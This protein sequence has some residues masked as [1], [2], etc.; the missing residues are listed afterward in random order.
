MIMQALENTIFTKV[1]SKTLHHVQA[2]KYEAAEGLVADIYEQMRRDL[3]VA[4]PF[5]LHS[6]LPQVMAGVWSIMRESMIAGP[7]NRAYLEAVAA[8]IAKIN[9]C[10]FCLEL[11]TGLMKGASADEGVA[12]LLQGTE[13]VEDPKL[14]SVIEW[15]LANRSPGSEMLRNP[16]FPKEEAPEYIGTAVFFHY[17]NRMVNVFLDKSPI[18]L[19]P[20]LGG[21]RGIIRKIFDSV[22]AKR[23]VHL[24]PAQGESLKFLPKANLPDDLSWADS[25]FAVSKAFAGLA[26]VIEELGQKMVPK[27]VRDMVHQRVQQWKGEDPG[28]SQS[29]LEEAVRPLSDSV[30]PTGR[31]TLL[32]AL[33][34]YRVD[35]N[36]IQ[37]FRQ[38]SPGDDQLVGVTTWAA[39]TAARKIGTWL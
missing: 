30:R 9:E 32:T 7:V 20:G 39:F 26:Y 29:W 31:L 16:P 6:P 35:E 27:D 1:A 17:L 28:L 33:A 36:I 19:P 24:T 23:I 18:F 12:M 15:G 13:R 4:P 21:L 22:I 5:T 8:S 11:H 10:P 2:V 37:E 25:N 3:A 34:A 14:R 38:H